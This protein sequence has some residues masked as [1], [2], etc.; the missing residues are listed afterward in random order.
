MLI[1][2]RE[3]SFGL[4]MI[5]P[6]DEMAM[7]TRLD[8]GD[9]CITG[10]GPND[11]VVSVGVEYK[12][13]PDFLQSEGNGRLAAQ[14]GEMVKVYDQSWLLTYGSYR[15]HP[16]SFSLQV[17][18]GKRWHTERRGGRDIPFGYIEGALL[19]LN[20]AGVYHKHVEDEQQAA[21]W[22][23]CLAK[24]W[25][26]PWDKHRS[27]HKFNNAGAF[28]VIPD[29]SPEILQRM[30]VA[31]TLPA[32]G[33]EKALAAA[34]SFNSVREMINASEQQWCDVP[35]VGKVIAKAIVQAVR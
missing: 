12:S 3:G 23:A 8:S 10:N 30:R 27:F 9:V 6:L 35:G 26:K 4:A 22:L 24:W 17:E 21:A 32:I 34:A 2:D 1:D 20:A 13:I 5:H 29:L 18:R 25:D 28:G 7:L 14:I 19:T 11:S 31:A 33:W 16:G 15:A